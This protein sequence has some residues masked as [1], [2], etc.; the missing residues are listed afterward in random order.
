L[1]RSFVAHIGPHLQTGLAGW[2]FGTLGNAG[3]VLPEKL[4]LS[5]IFSL[6]AQILGVTWQAIRAQVVKRV[7]P[8]AEKVMDQVEKSVAWVGNLITKGPIALLDMAKEFLGELPALFFDAFIGWL[9]NTIIVRAV[10]KLISMF[11]PVGAIVQAVMT[12]YNMVQFFIERAK[13]IAALV[14][15]V[16]SSI[17]EI[18]AGN[19]KKAVAAVEDSLVKALPVAISFLA[20]LV[21]IGGIT[22]KIKEIIQKIRKPI[23]EAVGKAVGFIAG[24]AKKFIAKISGSE[25]LD[26]KIKERTKTAYDFYKEAGFSEDKI[27]R[28]MKGIKF[29]KDVEVIEIKKNQQVA[30]WEH[31][32]YGKGDYYSEIPPAKPTKLGISSKVREKITG[33]LI[34]RN[35]KYYRVIKDTTALKSTAEGV[36][37]D[38][39]DSIKPIKTKGG[40]VQLFSPDKSAFQEISEE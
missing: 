13:Q 24:K 20:N 17:G 2:L 4:N 9:R 10:E 6:M 26:E 35:L 15:A 8:M 40:A 11:N 37:D 39:S 23:D 1:L 38:W 34:K 19:L 16:F 21:G 3:I 30:Q 27:N 25:K 22:A 28:H 5:G 29:T 36:V 14:N 32:I 31:P 33:E 18:A 7:G 12:I